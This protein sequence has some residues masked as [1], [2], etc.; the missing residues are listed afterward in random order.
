MDHGI[1]GIGVDI[2]EIERIRKILRKND[3][4]IKKKIFTKKEI[5]YC[6]KKNNPYMHFSGKYAAKEAV[7]KAL[8]IKGK[9][10][11]LSNIEILN[12][13][14]GLP[15]VLL[16]SAIKHLMKKEGIRRILISISHEKTYAIAYSI[17][18]Y[19]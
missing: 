7:Y 15:R 3:N 14:H 4:E 12:D 8:K 11:P 1:H 17:T 19:E 13:E 9:K 5:D 18:S 6:E 10:F 2:I 16:N